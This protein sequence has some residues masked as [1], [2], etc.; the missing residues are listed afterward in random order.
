[1]VASHDLSEICIRRP[2]LAIVM[3][4]ILVI[5][6]IVSFLFLGVREYPAVDPPVITVE[7]RYA[8]ASADIMDSQITEPLEQVINGIAGIRVISSSSTQGR[9][10]IR[11]EFDIS[12]DIEQAANDV[13]DKVFQ[14]VRQLPDD[15]EPPTVEK[16]D[17]DADPIIFMMLR[18]DQRSILEISNLA[19]TVIKERLQTIPGVSSVRIYGEKRY[20]MRLWMDPAKLAAH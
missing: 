11:V 6:G 1:L 5:L 10:S 2:V 20:A 15:A 9:S 13:R 3:S 14:A 4:L 18:S 19:S 12:S 17:A 16:A 7:T 8:G